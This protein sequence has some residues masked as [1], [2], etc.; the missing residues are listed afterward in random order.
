MLGVIKQMKKH[1]ENIFSRVN[2][3]LANFELGL[4]L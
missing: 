4:K 2:K 3:R 1:L